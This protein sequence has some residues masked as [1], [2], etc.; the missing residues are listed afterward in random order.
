MTDVLLFKSI[1]IIAAA[2]VAVMI[3]ARMKLPTVLGYLLAGMLIG[4]HGIDV[5]AE[6][7]ETR[8]LAELGVIFLMFMAGM[9]LSVPAVRQAWRHVVVGGSLQI[10]LTTF[11]VAAAAVLAGI[12]PA[13]AFI[14][15]GAAAMSSTALTVKQVAD[16]GELASQ[17]ARFALGILLFQDLAT[18]VFLFGIDAWQRKEEA[19]AVDVAVRFLL[20][21]GA[22]AA[23]ALACP[24][25]FRT[26]LSFVARMRSAELFL[27]VVLLLAL[28]AAFAMHLAGVSPPIGAFVAGIVLGGSDFRHQAAD[29]IRPFR[30]VLVG[31][32]FISVGMRIDP[33]VAI[34][35][36]LAAAVFVIALVPGKALIIL[37]VGLVMRWPVQL[38]ARVAAIL[39]HG[40]E[41]GLLLVTQ[42]MTAGAIAEPIG[43]VALFTLAMT[44]G[45][46]PILI[47]K[48]GRI[49]E[50]VT[51]GPRR[52]QDSSEE[53]AA[54]QASHRLDN[55]VLLCGCGRVGQLVATALE[56]ANLPY[57]AIESEIERFRQAKRQGHNVVFGDATRTG[58][59]EAAGVARACAIA[60]TF[61]HPLAVDRIVHFARQRNPRAS[62]VVSAGDERL[63]ADS[64]AAG[65]VTVLP[66]NFAA[67]LELAG[68]VLVLSGL[69]RNLATD[70]LGKI[71]TRLN[72][73]Q[74]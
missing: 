43:Q 47:Q 61:D 4:P 72:K 16:Q 55:H 29:D 73:E 52:R 2:A 11:A 70:V 34:G 8:F 1:V 23:I 48:N 27:L 20:A 6:S 65:T 45:L 12:D 3:L 38:S 35:M 14:L 28:G 58:L 56:A 53:T 21:G 57:V 59:L 36:P 18:L 30:D 42:G 10:S 69:D 49:A 50:L 68:H 44:M 37:L 60:V 9:E 40:G 25:V 31:L 24:P 46:A 17:H 7:A 67:G 33:V 22:I 26:L 64:V 19:F 32:F 62:V 5:L 13:A 63:L 74:G 54:L 41:F 71:R 15:G 51:A 66:E 39:A